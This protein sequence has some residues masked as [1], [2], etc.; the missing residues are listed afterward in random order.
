MKQYS[1]LMESNQN[2]ITYYVRDPKE[3]NDSNILDC[4]KLINQLGNDQINYDKKLSLTP[5]AD[6]ISFSK[7]GWNSYLNKGGVIYQIFFTAEVDNHIVGLIHYREYKDQYNEYHGKYG[8]F[9][10]IVVDPEYRQMGIGS[11]LMKLAKDYIK[12]ERPSVMVFLGVS[13]NNPGGLAL[14]NKFGFKPVHQTMVCK[15]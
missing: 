15:L 11:K 2:E 14:Y 5:Y 4:C 10:T 9:P 3:F 1:F 6:Q 12:K 13:C 7:S 8:W